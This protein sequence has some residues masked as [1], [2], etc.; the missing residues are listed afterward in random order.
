MTTSGKNIDS[1]EKSLL[2]K[3]MEDPNIRK[4]GMD[5]LKDKVQDPEFQKQA[6]AKGAE[7]GKKGLE[8]GLDYGGQG[9]SSFRSY[10]QSGPSGVR[11]LCFLGGCVTTVISFLNFL[12]IFAL[13]LE[14]ISFVL[15]AYTLI[16]GIIT[17]CIEADADQLEAF[18]VFCF[19]AGR[20]SKTQEWLHENSKFLTLL[21]GR[22]IFYIMVGM[23][24]WSESSIFF[25]V[26][27]LANTINGVL[28]LAMFMGYNPDAAIDALVPSSEREFQQ[29]EKTFDE[30]SSTLSHK[31]IKEL[32]ALRDQANNGDLDPVAN[33][34]P[35]GWLQVA[36]KAQ[37][38]ARK[39]LCGMDRSVAR[40]EF[41]VRLRQ[42]KII[43]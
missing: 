12:N 18:P 7:L 6:M 38:E 35:S 3:G 39:K 32:S 25:L 2:E 14:P 10:V 42:E 20:V 17:I 13:L 29:A 24:L 41:V 1:M 19:V 26:A 31:A 36:A 33:P 9:L 43:D 34:R 4:A 21:G 5:V 37:W 11:M 8:L 30:K 23:V 28:C 27:G 16:F 40:N 15:N 22:G